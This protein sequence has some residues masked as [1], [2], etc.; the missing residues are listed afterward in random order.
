MATVAE[1]PNG[2]RAES[3]LPTLPEQF[4]SPQP[5]KSRSILDQLR[6]RRDELQRLGKSPQASQRRPTVLEQLKARLAERDAAYDLEMASPPGVDPNYTRPE[7]PPGYATRNPQATV[8][9]A[10]TPNADPARQIQ[11]GAQG[12]GRGLAG[13]AGLPVDLMEMGLNAPAALV[14]ALA[15]TDLPRF[16]NSVGSSESIANTARDATEALLGDVLIE[17]SEMTPDE[18]VRYAI[19]RFGTEGVVGGGALSAGRN[20][21][22][23]ALTAPYAA[24][25]SE[26][27]VLLGDT[28]A[29]AGSGAAMQSYA[30]YVPPEIQEALGPV[31]QIIAG[32]V[33]GVGGAGLTNA[34]EAVA[35][36]SVRNADPR[37]TMP[38]VVVPRDPTTQQ[39]IARRDFSNAAHL[40][41]RS[42]PSD[43]EF[44]QAK[45][46]IEDYL[47]ELSTDGEVG[48]G[49]HPTTALIADD[50]TMLAAERRARTQ[51]SAPFIQA[52]RAVMNDVS[53]RMRSVRPEDGDPTAPI[54]LAEALADERLN[55]ADSGVI[56]ARNALRKN[57]EMEKDLASSVSIE[58]ADQ[59][60]RDLDRVLVEQ[61]YVPERTRKNALYEEAAEDPQAMVRLDRTAE[62][63]SDLSSRQQ[64]LA[65]PLRDSESLRIADGFAQGGEDGATT[66]HLRNV[67][68]DRSALGR[69]E[70]ESRFQ[71][72]FNKADTV[73]RLRASINADIEGS[74]GASPKLRAAD[75][76][77]RERFAPYFRDGTVSPRFFESIDRDPSRQASVPEATASKFLTAGPTSRAAA[78]DLAG[79]LEIAPNAEE[80]LAAATDYLIA[81]AVGKGIIRK[82]KISDT[83]LAGYMARREG[84][85]RELPET[86]DRFNRLLSDVRARST[87]TNELGERLKSAEEHA[88]LTERQINKGALSL[89]ID[90]SPDKAVAAVFA[91]Q[92]PPARMR[93][94]VG[95]FSG[96]EI[97]ADGWKAAV[98]D[99]LSRK[100]SSASKSAVSDGF[101]TT[102]LAALRRMFEQNRV[103]LAEV[104]S[105]DEMQTLQQAQARLEILSKRGVQASAGSATAENVGG[106]QAII[107]AFASP[108]GF[109]TTLSRGALY[110]GSYERRMRLLA[111]QFP[112]ANAAAREILARAQFD[113]V[114]TKHLMDFPTSD[115]Q[116]Y[117]WSKRLNQLIV[118]SGAEDAAPTT[119][120]IAN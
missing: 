71:G 47:A 67:L 68:A 102:S 85:Y 112:D 116:I 93:E 72:A 70:K 83:A 35:R 88:K 55:A 77:Y 15:G 65:P 19:N 52:D 31:G 99:H 39:P 89:L 74:L 105:P 60:S 12:V 9:A 13:I 79:I 6:E 41:R 14:D 115:A 45:K 54:G 87:Q 50:P 58:S 29:G 114:L 56:R 4:T 3:G 8:P 107:A 7:P 48:P 57:D 101:D 90:H 18:R 61:T 21:L 91:N 27:R 62:A 80:G 75:E 86:G 59:A 119:V 82:G 36:S 46:N 24:P 96:N 63:A 94:L 100:A 51:D 104:F 118:L 117:T 84:I 98:A 78:A 66:K 42:F 95:E 22:P 32:L 40:M 113:P 37:R 109:V 34:T 16:E 30:E 103:A 120:D 49:P 43:A 64:R 69:I 38:D 2:L 10:T 11:I 106:L 92:D 25:G 111:Q 76:N 110:G 5:R 108:V 53:D 1:Q 23:A 73:R 17:Q 81:D 26:A 20:V 28:A 33:G 97:A 44:D